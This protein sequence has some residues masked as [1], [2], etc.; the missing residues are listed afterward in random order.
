MSSLP[1]VLIVDDEV[2]GLETLQRILQD[3]FDV[4]IAENVKQATEILENE[5][6]QIILCDQRMPDIT[7]VEFLKQVRDQWP[8]V[9]RM[10]I[11]GYTD[12]EDIISAVN[13]A[14]IY[15]FITKPW[16][17][18]S[19]I[20]LLKNAAELFDL[21][22]KNEILSIELKM[23]P[24]RLQAAMDKKRKRLRDEYQCEDQ[25]V[26]SPQSCMNQVCEKIRR[27]SPYDVSVLL[28]GESGTGKELA[29]RALHYNSTRW[30]QP[31]VVENCGALPDELL[32]SELFGYKRG[33]FTGAVEDRAGLFERASGGTVFLDEIGEVSPAFQVKLLRVLQEGE[34]RPLGSS[35]T[36]QV[37][38]RVIAATNR[39][40]EQEVREGR[41]RED[42]YYRL[43]TVTIHL[44]ALRERKTDIPLIANSILDGAIQHL[45]KQV[46]GFSAEAIA[47]MQAYHWPGNVRELQN[48]IRH[49]LVMSDMD[50]M[51]AELLSPR[52]LR[53][54]PE[55]DEADLQTMGVLEGSLKERV[56]SLEARILKET[57]IRHR[58]N[59]SQA[60]KELGLSR[61][62]LRSKLERYGLEKVE[63]LRDQDERDAVG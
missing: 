44:P 54:A 39:D 48:E 29:A 13:D 30:D 23:S 9:I 49:M 27:V 24:T 2:R 58:W 10:I 41:F 38:V 42:L 55:G 47:C 21:Q 60:A 35:Q 43:A 20:L 15:Q 56:E 57:L 6:V 61:V 45:G 11:S 4:R 25:I 52:V 14:G 50:E 31:F 3:D 33:A 59:K 63:Q 28:T 7:G 8:E 32:E 1:T 22:R 53:A 34:I 19:L 37:D 16:H 17:P 46:D 62:G 26:R 12:S 5:W 40:L 18:D 36:R 51:G